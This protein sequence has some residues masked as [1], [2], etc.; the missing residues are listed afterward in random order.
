M[1]LKKVEGKGQSIIYVACSKFKQPGVAA[2]YNVS[3]TLFS[4]ATNNTFYDKHVL[5]EG[6]SSRDTW[7]ARQGSLTN[8]GFDAAKMV[9]AGNLGIFTGSNRSTFIRLKNINIKD[10]VYGMAKALLE[11]HLAGAW[12]NVG[13]YNVHLPV[14]A[15]FQ[16]AD[17]V[18]SYDAAGAKSYGRSI[19][20]GGRL[21]AAAGTDLSFDL[22]H[23]GGSGTV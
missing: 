18:V 12:P 15:V 23:C 17:C 3:V 11:N 6:E 19:L 10:M 13:D 9:A 20:M 2:P 8:A 1:Q 16:P 21:V 5:R 4:H 7:D 14:Q 22:N